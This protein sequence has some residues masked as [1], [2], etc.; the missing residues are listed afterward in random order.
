MDEI[1]Y[2]PDAHALR[3]PNNI[4][5][6]EIEDTHPISVDKLKKILSTW[7]G[8]HDKS[9]SF[10]LFIVDR[11]G[12]TEKELDLDTLERCIYEFPAYWGD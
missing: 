10:Q 2:I 3:E 1:S 4:V 7:M 9:L 5:I 8:M 11:Y 6:Y 12:H